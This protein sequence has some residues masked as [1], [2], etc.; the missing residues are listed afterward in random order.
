M[1]PYPGCCPPPRLPPVSNLCLRSCRSWC[2]SPS[3]A[4]RDASVFSAIAN[5]PM[6]LSLPRSSDSACSMSAAMSSWCCCDACWMLRGVSAAAAA[7]SRVVDAN[8]RVSLSPGA[9]LCLGETAS[10][11]MDAIFA[12]SCSTCCSRSRSF[13][14]CASAARCMVLYTAAGTA[15]AV[16][17]PVPVEVMDM[18]PVIPN[19][20]DS[21]SSRCASRT[22]LVSSRS[23]S[24]SRS[25]LADLRFSKSSFSLNER[26]SLSS[27][28]L[29]TVAALAF[30]L[31]SSHCPVVM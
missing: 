31:K 12:R 26:T 24:M 17:F 1:S 16:K 14:S 18:E 11:S 15:V 21:F 27:A 4:R 19:P 23:A 28:S 29:R 10:F 7:M 20:P 8:A 13:K 2:A 5:F 25:S 3:A 6:S 22:F 9:S 30:A